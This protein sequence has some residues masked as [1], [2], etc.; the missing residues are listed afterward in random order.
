MPTSLCDFMSRN[1][2]MSSSSSIAT[3]SSPVAMNDDYSSHA[4]PADGH[5]VSNSFT[6]A[7]VV[8]RLAPSDESSKT[9]SSEGPDTYSTSSSRPTRAFVGSFRG[10][11]RICIWLYSNNSTRQMW[12]KLEAILSGKLSSILKVQKIDN[13]RFDVYVTDCDLQYVYIKLR[14]TRHVIHGYVK[15][16]ESYWRRHNKQSSSI[17]SKLTL[18]NEKLMTTNVNIATL[19]IFS[20][21]NKNSEIAFLLERENL[22]ILSLQ[23]TKRNQYSMPCKFNGYKVYESRAGDTK[24]ANGLMMI[25][26]EKYASFEIFDNTPYT[27]CIQVYLGTEEWIIINIYLPSPSRLRRE[28]LNY[29][30][31]VIGKIKMKLANSK[32][33]IVGDWNSSSV[34][35]HKKIFPSLPIQFQFVKCRGS[36]KTFH[37]NGLWTSIDH[38]A[39]SELHD[40]LLPFVEVDR[41]YDLSADHWL[42]KGKI[43]IT[44]NV[45]NKDS[46]PNLKRLNCFDII[47]N[48]DKIANHNR[49][50]ILLE[51]DID[52]EP[53]ESLLDNFKSVVYEVADDLNI[54]TSSNKRKRYAYKLSGAAKKSV[55]RRR[56]A[57]LRWVRDEAP[58][59]GKLWDCYMSLK[60]K[61]KSFQRKSVLVSWNKSLKKGIDASKEKSSKSFWNWVNH[62]AGRKT[63]CSSLIGPLYVNGLDGPKV[64]S[65]SEKLTVGKQYYKTLFDDVRGTSKDKEYWKEVFPGEPSQILPGMNDIIIWAELNG[66]L[67]K[68]KNWKSPGFDGIPAEFYKSCYQK[69]TEYDFD[70]LTPNTHLGK[71]LLKYTNRLL[72]DGVPASWN[73]AILTSI[74]KDGDIA[75]LSNYR[76]IALIC[77]IIKLVTI[78]VDS[79]IR[80]GLEANDYIASEQAGF[81]SREECMGHVCALYEILKRRMDKGKQTFVSFI[82]FKKAY[83]M[84]PHEA[85]L[86]KF[87]LAGVNGH[88]FNFINSLYSNSTILVKLGMHLTESIEVIRGLRQ[89]CPGSP[90]GFDVFINDLLDTCRHLGIEVVGIT[91][92]KVVGLKFADDVAL[93]CDSINKLRRVL[94]CIEQWASTNHME[95]GIKKCGIMGIGGKAM[96]NIR[97]CDPILLNNQQIPIVDSYKYLGVQI[98]YD[99]D[100][101]VI[102]LQRAEKGRRALAA[103]RPVLA[104]LD[105]PIKFKVIMIKTLLL[106]VLTYGAELWGMSSTRCEPQQRV[107]NSAMKAVIRSS[108]YSKAASV[109]CLLEEF[110]LNPINSIAAALRAR[111]YIKFPTLKTTI[112]TLCNHKQPSSVK[113]SWLSGTKM[114]ISSRETNLG[115]R[116]I[117]P[118]EPK[119]SYD[120]ILTAVR[121]KF[122]IT[123][124]GVSYTRYISRGFDTTKGYIND[125]T[126]HLGVSNGLHWLARSRMGALW[127]SRR[128]AKGKLLPDLALTR[129]P[130]CDSDNEPETLAHMFLD[131]DCWNGLRKQYLGSLIEEGLRLLNQPVN[132]LVREL[133]ISDK[134]H[135]I[136]LLLGG[137][138]NS[139]LVDNVVTTIGLKHWLISKSKQHEVPHP[140]IIQQAILQ[141][142]QLNIEDLGVNLVGEVRDRQPQ[143]YLQ[144][145]KFLHHVMMKRLGGLLKIRNVSPRADAIPSGR[146]TFVTHVTSGIRSN[147]YG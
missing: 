61:A 126:N 48:Q 26:N 96:T 122:L 34:L 86:R 18:S 113:R 90:L 118:N 129:C 27:Q 75:A 137:R 98:T 121:D 140:Q 24:G 62:L 108:K 112:A 36:S 4:T 37:R 136:T 143:G 52:D 41:S 81:R 123:E 119:N 44:N 13:K 71:V 73:K 132:S 1:P 10:C 67:A 78:I 128:L 111:A 50:A 22:G 64:F 33:V 5:G 147:G 32:V 77:V 14:N 74:Y 57:Y 16:H 130:F 103:I 55:G 139:G 59:N 124:V 68:L 30:R 105:I 92:F 116:L 117:I 43:H 21:N 110:E 38:F 84:V 39:I 125:V 107:L 46:K 102:S 145:A 35:I 70:P 63:K 100:L 11:S 51:D 69:T 49:F 101:N 142:N 106:P 12:N 120:N 6:Y 66:A 85:L 19:N 104:K 133:P 127:T 141:D 80:V 89:G 8:R 114:W 9:D 144:V 109:H 65:T 97:N 72:V 99:L 131:C 23:E 29:L 53:I 31:I 17:K 25:V 45:V 115:V 7:D 82:D 47:K 28:A 91:N 20:M 88:C 87:E 60:S 42:M 138:I 134:N 94:R 54:S 76:G 79:R 146:A 56:V 15:L 83:D 2:T 58:V 93:I 135:L 40:D 95:F 3:N